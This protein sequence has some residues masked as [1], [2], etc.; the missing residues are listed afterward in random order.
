M[1]CVNFRNYMHKYIDGELSE[2]LKLEFEQHRDECPM[3]KMFLEEELYL[4]S[5]IKDIKEKETEYICKESNK[6]EN[7][8]EKNTYSKKQAVNTIKVMYYI[9][10]AIVIFLM[11]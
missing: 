7:I 10:P 6:R 11:G 4:E 5:L 2:E 1:E 8:N 9:A 3:C